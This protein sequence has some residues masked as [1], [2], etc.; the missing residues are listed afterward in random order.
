MVTIPVTKFSKA[1]V[2][3]RARTASDQSKFFERAWENFCSQKFP[4]IFLSKSQHGTGSR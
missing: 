3:R 1:F 2:T 4:Q